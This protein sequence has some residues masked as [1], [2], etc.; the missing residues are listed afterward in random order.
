MG[1]F[2]EAKVHKT[3]YISVAKSEKEKEKEYFMPW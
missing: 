2:S 3:H 1:S